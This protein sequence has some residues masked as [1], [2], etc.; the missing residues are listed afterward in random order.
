MDIDV[1][2]SKKDPR[3]ARTMDFVKRWVR[4]CGV[5]AKI[6]ET[7]KDVN[8]PTVIINGHTLRDLRKSPRG[9]K[10]AMYPTTKDIAKELE[11]H[12]WCL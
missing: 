3:Q 8:S 10:P 5:L 4:D 12:V 9:T 1:I 2:Y 7:E 11:R 6:V